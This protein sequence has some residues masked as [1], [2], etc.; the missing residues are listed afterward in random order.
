ML[1]L[2]GVCMCVYI[3]LLCYICIVVVFDKSVLK[4]IFC[5]VFSI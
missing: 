2:L 4:V 3:V 5:I 1:K